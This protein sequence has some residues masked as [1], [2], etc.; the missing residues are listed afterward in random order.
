MTIREYER[1]IIE[2]AQNLVFKQ[3]KLIDSE[4]KLDISELDAADKL[5]IVSQ[6]INLNANLDAHIQEYLNEA[7]MHRMYAESQWF[8]GWND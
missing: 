8:G 6:I 7:C 2:L 4:Y 1:P 5:Q 3:A